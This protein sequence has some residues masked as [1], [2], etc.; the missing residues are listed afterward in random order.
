MDITTQSK[1]RAFR[2]AMP[3][4]ARIALTVEEGAAIHHWHLQIQHDQ[5]GS[6]LRISDFIKRPLP[7]LCTRDRVTV[8]LK[9]LA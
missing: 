1:K 8:G 7:I 4:E 2:V 5:P 3:A 9:K 6:N